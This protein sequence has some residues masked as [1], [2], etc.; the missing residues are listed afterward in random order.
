MRAIAW[1]LALWL[2]AS[3]GWAA[4]AAD[5]RVPQDYPTIQAAV[6]AARSRDVVLISPGIYRGDVVIDSK[7][8]VLV[9][10]DVDLLLDPDEPCWDA[11][12]ADAGLCVIIGTVHVRSCVRVTIEQLTILGPGPALA[13]DGS[14]TCYASDIAVRYC[15][16]ISGHGAAIS[17]GTFY[18]R[19][20]IS[21]TNTQ[22][23]EPG[24]PMIDPMAGSNPDV[25]LTCS[26]TTYRP[27]T[28]NLTAS[29]PAD[30]VVAV[31][32]SG[33][34]RT[35]PAISCRVWTNPLEIPGNGIDDDANGYV[36]DVHGWDF[37]DDDADSLVGSPLHWH[38][39]FVAGLVVDAVESHFPAGV[40]CTVRVM[41]LRFLDE[42][43]LFY[44]GDWDRLTAAIDY[45]VAQGARIINLSLYASRIPP[46]RVRDAIRDAEEAGVL[47]VAIAGNDAGRLG[48]IASWNE[49]TTVGAVDRELRLAAFSNVG[50]ELD[51]VSY[52]VGVLS[53]VPGGALRISSGTSFAAP[54]VAGLAAFH[55]A[56]R[57]EISV[58]ELVQLLR[59]QAI[60][61]GEPGHDP[62][63]GWGAI[64]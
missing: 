50:D 10:S 24:A 60:D 62:E 25:L 4:S 38:G 52:G 20:A 63:T 53:L 9:R 23:L 13:I 36:D 40:P 31:I 29:A 30:V 61:L 6:D 1:G 46:D 14:D 44:T 22:L 8:D 56:S 41:D 18:R 19:L 57:P 39:T 17:L 35:I 59:E 55:V 45:A 27:A 43:G 21:C 2:L 7:V 3:I 47:V 42:Q 26:R 16:L 37:R 12:Q 34:D 33:I 5:L 58:T 28:V 54:L 51:L 11:V 64:E 49:V 32:D 48:P 15:N